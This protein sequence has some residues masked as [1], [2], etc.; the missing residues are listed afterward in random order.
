MTIL[1]LKHDVAA[2]SLSHGCQ[3]Y[4]QT[5]WARVLF[6]NETGKENSSGHKD[7]SSGQLALNADRTWPSPTTVGRFLQVLCVGAQVVY[8]SNIFVYKICVFSRD[9]APTTVRQYK[10]SYTLCIWEYVLNWI[11]RAVFFPVFRT[12]AGSTIMLLT[13]PWLGG[14][15]LGRVD[16]ISG[17][18]RDNQCSR[19]TLK[20]FYKQ[21]CFMCE[22][23]S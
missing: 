1:R 21:V 2:I 19:F 7:A 23:I 3:C 13:L 9:F 14:L 4:S 8:Y 22:L 20:S 11:L 15:I 5:E 10:L 16:I 18:G 6:G 17:V 12:L